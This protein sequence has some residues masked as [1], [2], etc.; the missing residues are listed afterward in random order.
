MGN[1]ASGVVDQIRKLD[2]LCSGGCLGDM[3]S[4]DCLPGS[5]VAISLSRYVAEPAYQLRNFGSEVVLDVT[6]VCFGVLHCVMQE[7]SGQHCIGMRNRG[8]YAGNRYRMGDVWLPGIL[9]GTS[10]NPV[11][12]LLV[13]LRR[14]DS[15]TTFPDETT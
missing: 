6:N 12:C 4:V 14:P 8:D 13:K 9:A 7:G 2:R 3:C 11:F 10:K 1:D 5:A 15:A